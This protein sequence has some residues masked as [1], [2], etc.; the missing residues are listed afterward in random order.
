MYFTKVVGNCSRFN[1]NIFLFLRNPYIKGDKVQKPCLFLAIIQKIIKKDVFQNHG[2]CKNKKNG[3][4]NM[5]HFQ[6]LL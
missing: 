6:Q 1:S 4:R 5:Y 3:N 2:F